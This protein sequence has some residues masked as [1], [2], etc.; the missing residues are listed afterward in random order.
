M[1]CT[2]SLLFYH[3]PPLLARVLDPVYGGVLSVLPELPSGLAPLVVTVVQLRPGL[4]R[5]HRLRRGLHRQ[6]HHQTGCCT[7]CVCVL[8][9]DD[10]CVAAAGSFLKLAAFQR[11]VCLLFLCSLRA[12]NG[13]L[14]D[15]SSIS[16]TLWSFWGPGRHFADGLK[17]EQRDFYAH[18][19]KPWGTFIRRRRRKPQKSAPREGKSSTRV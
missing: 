10:R 15:V 11:L 1:Q 4:G 8:Q 7:M 5:R 6:P 13:L 2:N 12:P 19:L 18:M 16:P 9:K 3:R 17:H 14:I